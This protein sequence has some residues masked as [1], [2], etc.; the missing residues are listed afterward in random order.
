MNNNERTAMNIYLSNASG[1]ALYEQIYDRIRTMI[2][3]GTLK[4]GQPLPTIRGLAKDLRISVITTSRA[5]ADLERDGYIYSVVGK[6]SFVSER[7]ADFVR[8]KNLEEMRSNLAAAAE[9]AARCGMS[10]E[11]FLKQAERAFGADKNNSGQYLP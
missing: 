1:K 11:E 9:L 4:A 7:N 6:G 5:Y 3:D 8:D 2:L 10:A